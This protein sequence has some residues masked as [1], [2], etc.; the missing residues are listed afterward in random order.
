MPM[1]AK[2]KM[3]AEDTTGWT[4][5]RRGA[6]YC[7]PRCGRG[8]T[9]AE[10]KAAD[11]AADALVAKMDA[12][13][14]GSMNGWE[15]RVWENL[16]WHYLVKLKI[17]KRAHLEIYPNKFVREETTYSAWL[18]TDHPG[19]QQVISKHFTDPYI[20]LNL[21]LDE[22]RERAATLTRWLDKIDRR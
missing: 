20:A 18:Q 1:L 9:H 13:D 3:R 11:D 4:P 7:S 14:D 16:G 10:F 6:I 2:N 21:M 8:C 12:F 19:I 15:K 17:D 5:V 22:A